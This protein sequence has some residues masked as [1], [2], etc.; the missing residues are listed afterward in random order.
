MCVAIDLPAN[1]L[2]LLHSQ[3][4]EQSIFISEDGRRFDTSEECQEWES[5]LVV[6]RKIRQRIWE[7]EFKTSA[8]GPIWCKENMGERCTDEYKLYGGLLHFDDD[9]FEGRLEDVC[10]DAVQS[11]MYRLRQEYSIGFD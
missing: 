2:L 3:M 6:I 4:I 1:L 11:Y 8:L 10:I 7:D 5:L 9:I